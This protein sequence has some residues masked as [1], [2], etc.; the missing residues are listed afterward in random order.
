MRILCRNLSIEILI[1]VAKIS[2]TIFI[3]FENIANM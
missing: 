2:L 1:T 3:R